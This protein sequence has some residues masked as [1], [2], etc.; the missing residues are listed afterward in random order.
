MS[1]IKKILVAIGFS[2][3]AEEIFSY[4]IGVARRFDSQIVVCNVINARDVAA[5]RTISEMGYEVDGD[6]YVQN[7]STDRH[8][9]MEQMIR[10]NAFPIERTQIII[11]VGNPVD[12][13]LKTVV[14]EKVDLVVMGIKGRTDLESIFVGSVAEKM[15]DRC[16]VPIL[17]YRDRKNAEKLRSRL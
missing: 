14:A 13:L 3:Y 15:F 4:A 6:H 12:E 5:V 7:V 9:R 10:E 8:S 17:S 2:E 1:D 16:P 11:S